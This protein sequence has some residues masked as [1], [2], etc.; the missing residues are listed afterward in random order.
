MSSPN[1]KAPETYKGQQPATQGSWHVSCVSLHSPQCCR[2][3]KQGVWS[4]AKDKGSSGRWESPAQ[5]AVC[6]CGEPV[7]WLLCAV[8]PMFASP[9]VRM[10]LVP[11]LHPEPVGS[12]DPEPSPGPYAQEAEALGHER[13]KM[14]STPLTLV[15]GI[16]CPQK[17]ALP[18]PASRPLLEALGTSQRRTAEQSRGPTGF[19]A[20]LTASGSS[21]STP[22]RTRT[23]V[24]LVGGGEGLLLP[25]G[26]LCHTRQV[27]ATSP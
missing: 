16:L 2:G 11:A 25:P 24:W 14:T 22:C 1:L 13:T 27:L 9:R 15:L 19:W 6:V 21:L 17:G 26:S 18:S 5:G 8:P 12:P 20:P 23:R 10:A 4:P 3:R 7:S